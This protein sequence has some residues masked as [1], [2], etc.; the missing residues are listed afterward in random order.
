M[1]GL[2]A[3]RTARSPA[4][5]RDPRD[6]VSGAKAIL[7]IVGSAL[8]GTMAMVGGCDLAPDVGP[9][10]QARCA[11]AD[12]DPSVPIS[13]AA[14]IE[15]VLAAACYRCHDPSM[16]DSVGTER[17]GLDLS[18]FDALRAGGG[19]T[20]TDIVSPEDPCGSLLYLKVLAGP[21]V[22]SRMPLGGAPL[23]AQQLDA[24]HDWVAEGATNN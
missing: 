9:L 10:Q 16:P 2:E 5:L 6:C 15:P 4:L 17:S 12:S 21:P 18:S 8:W 23:T 7:F 1:S 19:T 11:A 20:G 3:D 13:F 24:I 22:G 14:D